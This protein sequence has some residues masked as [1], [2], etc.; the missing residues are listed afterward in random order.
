MYMKF[1]LVTKSCV[2][3]VMRIIDSNYL[4][5][6]EQIAITTKACTVQ[7]LWEVYNSVHC[8]T[9]SLPMLQLSPL[10]LDAGGCVFR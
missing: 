4:K 9:I 1:N 6:F 5:I 7:F 2:P 3:V 8:L 10:Y